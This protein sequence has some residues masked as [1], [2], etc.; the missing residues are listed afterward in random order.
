[1]TTPD[2]LHLLVTQTWQVT[3]IAM[4]VWLVARTLAKNQPQLAHL[5]WAIVLLKVLTPPIWSSPVGVFSWLE[6]TC[7]TYLP[8]GQ[9]INAHSTGELVLAIQPPSADARVISDAFTTQPSSEAWDAMAAGQARSFPGT[10]GHRQTWNWKRWL[11]VLWLCGTAASLALAVVR[12]FR[13]AGWV[14]S[15]D[16]RPAASTES[17]EQLQERLAS[18]LQ[19]VALKLCVRRRVAI[20]IV[21]A[22]IGPA[23]FGLWRPTIV[24]SAAVLRD[25]SDA[26]LEP[27][28]AHELVHIRRGDLWWAG[29]QTL[30]TSLFWFHP[31]VWLASRMLTRESERSCD[32]QTIAGL[33][34]SAATYARGLLD[35]LERK[36]QLR[37]APAL[38]GVRPVDITR[39]RLERIM[40]LGQGSRRTTPVWAWSI[41]I[42]CVVVLLP[43]GAWLS[44]QESG[45]T[46]TLQVVPDP[47][48]LPQPLPEPPLAPPASGPWPERIER[49][50]FE[51]GDLLEQLEAMGNSR[52]QAEVML[53][54]F[55]PRRTLD[56]VN[57]EAAKYDAEMSGLPTPSIEGSTLELMETHEQIAFVES[58]LERLRKYGFRQVAVHVYFISLSKDR[59]EKLGID[60]RQ[61]LPWERPE[62]N[63]REGGLVVAASMAG[64]GSLQIVSSNP[65]HIKTL[66]VP[67]TPVPTFSA[68]LER[69]QAARLID[70]AQSDA[71]S[72]ILQAPRITLFNGVEATIVDSVQ[73]PFL[74]GIGF[75]L[76]DEH[77]R[78]GK[79]PF[80]ELA[81]T[82]TKLR[83]TP[84]IQE[85]HTIELSVALTYSFL[86]DVQTFTFDKLKYADGTVVKGTTIQIPDMVSKG[87]SVQ[88]EIEPGQT[89]AFTSGVPLDSRK[90]TVEIALATAVE[91]DVNA[92][93][94]AAEAATTP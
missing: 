52:A 12:L 67:V 61:T 86:R 48:P 80:I 26:E 78:R 42:G 5:L 88:A 41:F 49:E 69:D 45:P 47:A 50:K 6:R 73:Q 85:G 74:T 62:S 8:A 65:T 25:R 66:Q 77:G 75:V 43:G 51:V 83:V 87:L 11:V 40:S 18:L 29:V 81:E 71:R 84:V 70:R 28:L 17:A 76:S 16:R 35:V 60:W 82:G 44:A 31:L 1:M 30:A 21:E 4:A 9:Q 72:N 59:M 92:A 68:V 23:V 3:A 19:R 27:L 79:L 33:G 37:V 24:L 34:C 55:I 46:D 32:E 94:H 93:N 53:L 58:Q 14:S 54:S 63:V 15:Y 89:L 56:Q 64:K 13:F 22:P 20:R 91:V 57:K 90:D 38:P 10:Q 7:S 2:V 39:S 36:N